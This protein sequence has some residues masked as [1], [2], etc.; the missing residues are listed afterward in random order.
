[1]SRRVVVV[2]LTALLFAAPARAQFG[3]LLDRVKDRAENGAEDE[4]GRQAEDAARGAVRGDAVKKK[5]A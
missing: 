2:C 5:D 3:G 1:M 4:V